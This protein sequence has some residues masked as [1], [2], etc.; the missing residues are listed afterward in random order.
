MNDNKSELI[1][2][3]RTMSNY[4]LISVGTGL[5][6]ETMFMPEAGYFDP[7][8]NIEYKIKKHEYRNVYINVYTVLRNIVSAI[9]STEDKHKFLDNNKSDSAIVS[10]FLDEYTEIERL[11]LAN[12]FL[13]ILYIVDYSKNKV[14][15][16]SDR[17]VINS[18]SD[19]LSSKQ[20]SFINKAVKKIKKEYYNNFL[21]NLKVN[22]VK[23]ENK[24]NK[25]YL[26]IVINKLKT[27]DNKLPLIG[28]SKNLIISHFAI[29]LLNLKYLS[30][31]T[32]LE[33][34]TGRLVNHKHFN[35]KYPELTNMDFT[36]I[37]PFTEKM[38]YVF[39]DSNL[40]KPVAA[41]YRK[42]LYNIFLKEGVNST[43]KGVITD[44]VIKK[45]IKDLD[46]EFWDLYKN[47][48]TIY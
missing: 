21:E 3:D 29:D 8:R 40:L 2:M 28:N 36:T 1:L 4:P 7:N 44:S 9:S 27:G 20:N 13:P 34:H 24:I 25:E 39:G 11:L 18:I 19:T 5:A 47:L 22:I 10:T 35:K 15:H 16:N 17:N 6:L 48:T 32:L 23:Y 14:V 26:N 41:K 33:T 43:T 12:D 46:P 45:H 30:N 37:V 42:S 38:Y 31:L